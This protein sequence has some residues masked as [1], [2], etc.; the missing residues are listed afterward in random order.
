MFSAVVSPVMICSWEADTEIV[1]I[2][3]H[4]AI[5]GSVTSR[6]WLF[7][8]RGKEGGGG[9]LVFVEFVANILFKFTSSRRSFDDGNKYREHKRNTIGA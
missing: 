2:L 7:L 8:L 5:N 4:A 1:P 6:C 3:R 9:K